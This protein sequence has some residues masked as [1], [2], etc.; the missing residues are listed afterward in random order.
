V[1]SSARGSLMADVEKGMIMSENPMR[2]VEARERFRRSVNQAQISDLLGLIT[3]NNTDLINYHEVANRLKARQQIEMGTQMVPLSQIVG[4]VGRYKDFTRTFLP[5]TNVSEERWARVD[6]AMNSLEGLPPVELFKIGEVY[7][8]K[9]GNHRV[10]VARANGSTHIEAYVTEVETEIPLTMDDIERDAW[11][12][13]AEHQKFLDRTG[14][15]EIRPNH[16]IRLTEP[17]RYELMLHHIEVHQ[18]LRNLELERAGAMQWLT[19]PEAVASWYDNVYLPVV[20]AIR[21]YDLMA[22]FPERTEADLYLWIAHHR[23]RLAKAYGL[24]PL[25]PQAAVATFAEVHSD[26]LLERTF[27]GLRVGLARI[28]GQGDRP[29]GMSEEEFREARARH[30]AGEI[31]ISEAEER[32]EAEEKQLVGAGGRLDPVLEKWLLIDD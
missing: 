10:S 28:L 14:L 13:K 16:N 9:D 27:K 4:S 25:T 15:E 3:G 1:D 8:V 30:D 2:E 12:I 24:A 5:R 20:Q 23:E 17:G 7:F 29:L 19:W 22:H 11:L 32:L 18:Y 21:D 26:M 31:T 6:A